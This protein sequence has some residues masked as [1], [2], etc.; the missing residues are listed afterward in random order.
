M[1]RLITIVVS[2][3][4]LAFTECKAQG[5]IFKRDTNNVN[6]ISVG[7]NEWPSADYEW[8][9]IERFLKYN[10]YQYSISVLRKSTMKKHYFRIGLNANYW[11]HKIGNQST[12]KNYSIS[13]FLG[14]GYNFFVGNKKRV[15]IFSE[16]RAVFFHYKSIY[17]NFATALVDEGK[18]HAYG[19][20]ILVGVR[21]S[22]KKISVCTDIGVAPA[23]YYDY[24][25]L[26]DTSYYSLRKSEGWGLGLLSL[27]GI[28]LEINLNAK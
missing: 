8:N 17:E 16:L 19:I 25:L 2:F 5:N 20:G 6:I 3:A 28:K 1:C 24:Y 26:K 15:S 13:P 12:I 9:D 23:Y 21:Y 27:L 4:L 14:V 18:L 10:H 22:F 11:Q 7:F